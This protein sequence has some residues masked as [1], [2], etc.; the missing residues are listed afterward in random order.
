M[1]NQA[2]QSEMFLQADKAPRQNQEARVQTG[3]EGAERND[4]RR[5]RPRRRSSHSGQG[6]QPSQIQHQQTKEGVSHEETAQ[7]QTRP[8]EKTRQ[9]AFSAQTNGGNQQGR[10]GRG[11]RPRQSRNYQEGR[12]NRESKEGRENRGLG[13]TRKSEGRS[14]ES[15]RYLPDWGTPPEPSQS[16]FRKKPVDQPLSGRSFTRRG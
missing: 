5:R 10:S 15:S 16:V 8:M 11:Q 12:E 7:N 9:E 2:E 6:N 14:Q 1:T 4:S 3:G 13:G